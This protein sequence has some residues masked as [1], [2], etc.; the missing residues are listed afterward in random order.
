MVNPVPSEE[1]KARSSPSNR[2]FYLCPSILRTASSRE[3]RQA[4]RRV[5]QPHAFVTDRMS[6]DAAGESRGK[7][8]KGA[9]DLTL[10]LDG[11]CV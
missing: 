4:S 5:E 11:K 8:S 7:G 1:L 6:E 2:H 9:A 3:H 10:L